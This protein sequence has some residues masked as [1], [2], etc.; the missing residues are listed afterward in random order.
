LCDHLQCIGWYLWKDF[1]LA[2]TD[3]SETFSGNVARDFMEVAKARSWEE[4]VR[5]LLLITRSLFLLGGLRYLTPRLGLPILPI[6]L[7]LHTLDVPGNADTTAA[8]L[9]LTTNLVDI[10]TPGSR[11]S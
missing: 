8:I 11:Q 5:R 3:F 10:T 1:K 9:S 7:I 2:I 6:S 4:T